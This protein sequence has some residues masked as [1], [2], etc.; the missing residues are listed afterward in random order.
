MK[1]ALPL[2]VRRTAAAIIG[3]ALVVLAGWAL[4]L[5]SARTL[6]S[7]GVSMKVNTAL[8][9]VLCG[10]ALFAAAAPGKR[11]SQFIRAS[12]ALAG[13]LASVT[14]LEYFL[15]RNLR[16]DEFLFTD[17]DTFGTVHPGRMAPNTAV[18]FL[19]VSAAL[20][21]L[22]WSRLRRPGILA[23]GFMALLTT[24]LGFAAI[25]GYA[26]QV[27]IGYGW[28]AYTAMALPTGVLLFVLGAATLRAA[29]D[30][31]GRHWHLPA[32]L[33]VGVAAEFAVLAASS[34]ISYHSAQRL[35]E[36]G[37]R[38]R[39]ISEAAS[40]AARREISALE[41]EAEALNERTF[42]VVP[43]AAFLA[44]GLYAGVLFYLNIEVAER[45]EDS[46]RLNAALERR[47]AERTAQLSLANRELEA[48]SYSVAHDLR[49]PLRSIDGFSRLI[50]R[51]A[52][53][54]L[55]PATRENL[56]RVRAAS[57]RMGGLIDDLLKL[58]HA[59]RVEMRRREL[60]LSALAAAEVA[61]LQTAEPGREVTFVLA[62]R[63][64]AHADSG[65]LRAVLQNLLH[66][67]W[68]FTARTPAARI[69][70]GCRA[71]PEGPAFFVA[72]N[73]AGFDP[74]YSD[75]LFMAFQRLHTTEEFP[76][77]GI[78]LATVQRIIHRHGGHVWA[79]GRVNA[80]ATLLFTLP[81][82]SAVT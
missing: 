74:A 58:S 19:L 45:A 11:H 9:F 39:I 6:H 21:L 24:L 35:T 15:G 55:D 18:A 13:F 46:A 75:K 62:P 26:S 69:E 65:L 73:G 66:N 70:F 56:D 3:A 50:L 16:I 76:G 17:T 28:G 40:G 43:I 22:G 36:I 52:A 1:R 57:S 54:R 47:V 41:A 53:A 51:D 61:Q 42:L 64:T 32:W 78:G 34:A 68:K 4:D 82:P 63:L 30:R 49:A 81:A 79:E 29:W 14:L 37:A 5:S 27:A 10:S 38:T 48:F 77:N 67:A 7:A 25:T 71:T 31:A 59:S 80:G 2:N 12:A 33:I 23:A 72:D 44:L 20:F 8:C 60:D